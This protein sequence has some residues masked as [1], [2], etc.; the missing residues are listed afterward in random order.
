[1]NPVG[2]LCVQISTN[3][4]PPDQIPILHITN[5]EVVIDGTIHASPVRYIVSPEYFG[6]KIRN[7]M[8]LL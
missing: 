7:R 6:K 1:M 5:S 8:V 3:E 4:L 2:S